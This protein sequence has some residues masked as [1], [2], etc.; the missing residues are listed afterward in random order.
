[1]PQ[2]TRRQRA[3]GLIRQQGRL[4]VR[5]DLAQNAC[6]ELVVDPAQPGEL[7]PPGGRV[8]AVHRVVDLVEHQPGHD[9]GQPEAVVAVEVRDADPGDVRGRD[10]GQQH[11]A[12][13]ALPRVEQEA[14]F[15]PAQEVPVVVARARRRLARRP[16]HHE[17]A[18]T[19]MLPAVITWTPRHCA[20]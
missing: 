18:H 11:L 8:V 7:V 15:V 13:G 14:L 9:P 12:L 5:R 17:F 3:E 20:A 16:E 2:P 10:P 19:P 6:G 1:M 4:A